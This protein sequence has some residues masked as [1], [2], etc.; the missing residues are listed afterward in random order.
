M[1]VMHVRR[2]AL[3]LT[4]FCALV[5]FVSGFGLGQF[6]I[7]GYGSIGSLASGLLISIATYAWF[8]NDSD[9]ELYPRSTSL[10][11]AFVALTPFVLPYYLLRSRGIGRGIAAIGVA[12]LIYVFYVIAAVLGVLSV[13]LLRI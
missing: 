1:L 10:N 11:I 13:R 5:G 3:A 12:I 8:R 4:I 7:P 2:P 6:K 9:R